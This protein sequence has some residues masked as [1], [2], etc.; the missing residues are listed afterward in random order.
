M[1]RLYEFGCDTCG[2]QAEVSGGEDAGYL[3]VTQTMSCLDCKR[4]VDVVVREAHP[5][6]LGSDAHIVGC[7]PR[8]RGRRVVPWDKNRLCPRCGGTMKKLDTGRVCF[9]D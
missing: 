9:W 7:C 8:C 1:G 2:Y 4:L 5:G 6:S 3:I